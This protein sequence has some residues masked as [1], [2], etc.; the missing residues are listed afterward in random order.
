MLRL[1]DRTLRLPAATA[2]AVRALLDGERLRVAD[3]PGLDPADA[4]VL[5]RRLV[6]EAVVLVDGAVDAS[7]SPPRRVR[8]APPEL[9]GDP[10]AGTAAPAAGYLLVEQ[11]GGWGRQ[12]LTSSRLDP[13]VGPR[14]PGARSRRDSGCC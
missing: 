5:A 3:L 9:R 11:P 12:A 1:P 4:L 13:A 7:R 10:L 6:R 8:G 14:C 2:K